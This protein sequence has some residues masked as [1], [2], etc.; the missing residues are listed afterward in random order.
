MDQF[1]SKGDQTRAALVETAFELF[2]R[3]GYHGTTIRQIA[4]GMGLTP[5]SLYNH[6][7]GKDEI[8]LTVVEAYHPLNKIA[9]LLAET[10]G[11]DVAQYIQIAAS[12]F[13]VALNEHPDLLNLAFVELVELEGRHLPALLESFQPQL[14]AFVQRLAASQEQL[15][16]ISV[17]A[18][19]RSFLGLLFSYELTGRMLRSAMG[20][21]ATSLGVL[22]DFIDIYLRGILRA[23]TSSR[24]GYERS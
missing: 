19:F 18:A 8:F 3:Q 6:F 14:M 24:A 23:E 20:P 15:R 13:A 2:S 1:F 17:Y 11:D 7:A 4:K 16:P 22:D 10:E 9:P 5:G 12:E 21:G